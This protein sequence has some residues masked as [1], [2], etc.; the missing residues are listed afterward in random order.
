MKRLVLNP[1]QVALVMKNGALERILTSGPHW[2]WFGEQTL[3]CDMT[4]PF[5]PPVDLSILLENRQLASMLDVIDV[6][7]HEIILQFEKGVF[8]GVLPPG[9]YAYWKGPIR[10]EFIRADRSKIWITEPVDRTILERMEMGPFVRSFI[11]EPYEK[12]LLFINRQLDRVLEPGT[13]HFWKNG[14]PVQVVKSDMR[15]LQ[16]EVSG[17]EL[18]TRDKA[19]LRI[20]FHAQYKML[21]FVKAYSEARDYDK[22]LYLALQLALR[23]FVGELTLD[24]LLERKGSVGAKV[25]EAV[26]PAAEKLGVE[27]VSCGIRDIILPGEIKEIMNQVLVAEKKA[28]ANIITRREETASTRSLLNTAK[29]MEENAML[30]KLKEME[31]VEKIA[32]KISN[33]SVAGG[34]DLV[35]QLKQIFVPH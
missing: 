2:T 26:R 12:G 22:Q 25:L 35:G 23:E 20:N 11:V 19:A 33:I 6:P 15:Q 7:E 3:I 24:E 1:W 30:F 28:Q 21:D 14:E 17:Q 16:L 13:Y 29:L 5:V 10:R 9:Q 4:K 34:G 32:E 8:R 18:L 27:V 31:Y